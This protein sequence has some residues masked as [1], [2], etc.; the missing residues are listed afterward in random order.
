MKIALVN[1]SPKYIDS[2]SG[3]ILD[4]MCPYLETEEIQKYQFNKPAVDEPVIDRLLANDAAIISLPLY[5]DSVPSHF[6]NCM[7]QIE[8]YRKKQKPKERSSCMVYAVVNNGFFDGRQNLPA[9]ECIRNWCNRCGFFFGQGLLFGGGG[10]AAAIKEMPEE[11][12]VKK[13]V[14]VYIRELC[15]N[16]TS[17]ESGVLRI[18]EPDFPEPE[19]KRNAESWML[20]CAEANGLTLEKLTKKWIP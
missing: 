3:Y 18:F 11:A 13:S 15:E 9:I 2:N 20:S 5:V 17:G 19:Y 14:L 10:M 4:L 7:V 1:G 6:L 16:V 12:P 8:E